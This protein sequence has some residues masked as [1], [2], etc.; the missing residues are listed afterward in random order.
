[1]L[2]LLGPSLQMVGVFEL[3]SSVLAIFFLPI[4]MFLLREFIIPLVKWLLDLD[5]TTQKVIGAIVLFG[6]AL[7][8]VLFFLGM[9]GLAMGGLT[10]TFAPV[11]A[12]ILAIMS[13]GLV[14][15][16]LILGVVALAVV[17]FWMAWKEN[18][19]NIRGWVEVI[20]ESV[21]Q[22]FEGIKEVISGII[23]IVKGMFSGDTELILAGFK[24]VWEGVKKIVTGIGK[25]ILGLF[26]VGGL[27]IIRLGKAAF[28][29]GKAIV[30]GIIRGIKHMVDAVR[31]AISD[32][33]PDPVK[34]L[35]GWAGSAVGGAF[36]KAKGLVG[37]QEGGIVTRPTLATIGERGPEAVIPLTKGGFGGVSVNITV[38]AS[39]S[40]SIDLDMLARRI[41]AEVTGQVERSLRR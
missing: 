34:K 24:K 6:A 22:I 28:E 25:T 14:P 32:L 12:V 15:L 1:M 30:T 21:K 41:G 18:F 4:A 5:P 23:D 19:G 17:A 16:M 26:A 37:L 33:I 35:I 20:W 39:V 3:L 36:G 31:D 29:L 7:G 13:F 27:V 8:T 9:F 2:G 10:T 40:N 38:N 11:V